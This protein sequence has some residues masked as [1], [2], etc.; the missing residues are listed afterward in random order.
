MSTKL[1]KTGSNIMAVLTTG[2][3]QQA[4]NT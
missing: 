3:L 1:F 4:M 2:Q